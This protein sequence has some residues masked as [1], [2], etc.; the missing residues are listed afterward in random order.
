MAEFN[1][2]KLISPDENIRLFFDHLQTVDPEMSVIL[3][4]YIYNL[5]PLPPTG[6]GRNTKRQQ[7][8]EAIESILDSMI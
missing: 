4:T 5:L 3:K 6:I 1:F 7:A 2:D 8:N